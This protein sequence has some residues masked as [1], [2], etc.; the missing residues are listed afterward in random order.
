MHTYAHSVVS[1]RARIPMREGGG[2]S[3]SCDA[4]SRLDVVLRWQEHVEAPDELL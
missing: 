4:L 2:G 1:V 3:A